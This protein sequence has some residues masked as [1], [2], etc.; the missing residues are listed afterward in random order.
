MVIGEIFRRCHFSHRDRPQNPMVC[1]TRQRGS[2]ERLFSKARLTELS[3]GGNSPTMVRQ[4]PRMSRQGRPGQRTSAWSPSRIPGSLTICSFRSTAA[5]VLG[6]A[7]NFSA[8]IASVNA[9]MASIASAI[10]R[11]ESNGSLKGKYGLVRGSVRDGLLQSMSRGEINRR[12][13]SSRDRRFEASNSA[14]RST[15]DVSVEVPLASEPCK[16]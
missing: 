11:K 7:R 4:M 2:Y 15:S 6:P 10:S 16:R 5:T 13:I 8:S 12:A 9:F 3:S 14:I 1:P